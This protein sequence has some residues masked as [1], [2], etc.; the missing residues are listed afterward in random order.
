[1]D[2]RETSAPLV[3]VYNA[4]SGL[5]NALTD[6]AHKTFAPRTYQCR[7]CA[8]TYSAF[9]MRGSWKQF[10][11]SLDRPFEFLHADELKRLYGVSGA[12]LPAIFKKEGGRLELLIDAEAINACRTMGDLKELIIGRLC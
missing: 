2:D 3:F 8:L 10:L 9:G 6:L 5:F 7:L 12:T 11:E 1:M 4:D